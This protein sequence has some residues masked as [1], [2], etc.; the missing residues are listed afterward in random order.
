MGGFE[1][2]AAGTTGALR[3][4]QAH[5]RGDAESHSRT[6]RPP[7][8]GDGRTGWGRKVLLQDGRGRVFRQR[9]RCA[10]QALSRSILRRR[11]ARAQF[12][13]RLRWVHG[14]L[15]VQRE[16]LAGQELPLFRRAEGC[17]AVRTDQSRRR[18]AIGRHGRRLRGLPSQDGGFG[19]ST[20]LGAGSFDVS[21]NCLRCLIARHAGASV[22]IEGSRLAAA[23]LQRAWQARAYQCRVTHRGSISRHTGRPVPRGCDRVRHLY[24]RAHGHAGVPLLKGL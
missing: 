13:H 21:R 15:P 24:R 3:H 1:R 20:G 17:T 19:R 5:A 14:R 4:R 10:R 6:G 7:A 9:R 18:E 2:L 12:L 22:Q 16:E 8:Q 11:R 23:H